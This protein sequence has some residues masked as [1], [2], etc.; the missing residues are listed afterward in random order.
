MHHSVKQFL[1]DPERLGT[2][3]KHYAIDPAQINTWCGEI[4]LTLMR[5]LSAQSTSS[6]N[7]RDILAPV[8]TGIEDSHPVHFYRWLATLFA[9]ARHNRWCLKNPTQRQRQDGHRSLHCAGYHTPSPLLT[10]RSIS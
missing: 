3:L 10:S 4:C 9:P 6:G 2:V 5:G 8:P 1:M 7:V